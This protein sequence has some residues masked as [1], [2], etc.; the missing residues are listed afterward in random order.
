MKIAKISIF[1]A[2]VA[3]ALTA[4]GGGGGSGGESSA[5]YEIT[6][7]A[8]KTL[9]PV[10]TANVGPGQGVYAPYSTT[11]Y[12][13][14]TTGGHA[15]PGGEDIFGCN[16]EGGL[17]TGSLYYLDGD[18]SHVVDVD[19]G[20][21]GKVKVPKAYRSITLG[22][23]SGG[24][25]FHFHAGDQAGN[26][27]ITCSVQDPRDKKT[28]STSVNITVGAAS[29]KAASVRTYGQSNR[30]GTQ[31]NT[32]N[33]ASSTVV[34]VQVLD[35]A[36]QPLPNT[37]V[38]NVQVSL[39]STTSAA[40]G[41]RLMAGGK[42]GSTLWISTVGG[43]GKF[44]VSSGRSEGPLVVDVLADRS[45][46]D[47]TNGIKDPIIGTFVIPVIS[48][49]A[50]VLEP[51]AITTTTITAATNGLPYSFVLGASGGE[52]PYT[53]SALSALPAGLSLSPSGVISGTP[54]V[55]TL[56]AVNF[57][58]QVTDAA[59]NVST[60]N[61]TLT[62]S[63]TVVVDPLTIVGCSNDPNALCKIGEVEKG[64]V[65]GGYALTATGG[66]AAGTVVWTSTGIP[67][68]LAIT[69]S[70]IISATGTAPATC[71]NADF[72]VTATKGTVSTT[73]KLRIVVT[74]CP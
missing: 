30:L 54:N 42:D 58:V 27:K 31:G 44:T 22:A 71:G 29:G 16:V 72:F 5:P 32:S 20:N 23:N 10:N 34:D 57:A 13:N 74:G 64:V 65:F 48:R 28:Y 4:C 60:A 41:A 40:P 50:P 61:F 63:G 56:G 17:D 53:W 18:D 69:P 70:G 52:A 37:T 15:I 25:S 12:V 73:S 11:L 68:W 2:V 26:A 1:S 14:S 36:D 8:D 62:V 33:L 45:D 39:R 49:I 21:G 66:P 6:L 47:V 3:A 55:R 59:G 7:R 9:L 19:D 38:Q 67:S 51:L 43:I 46:N 24:N 35:D